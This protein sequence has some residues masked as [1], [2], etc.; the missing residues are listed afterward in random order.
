M[1]TWPSTLPAPLL[2]NYGLQ[3]TDP[4]ARTQMEQGSPRTRQRARL[5][6]TSVVVQWMLTTQQLATLEAWHREI[7]HNGADWFSI[8]LAN[9]LG[10]NTISARF[11]GMWKAS[12]KERGF[13]QIDATLEIADRPML[14]ATQLTPYL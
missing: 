7:I 6:P 14:T 8:S 2:A 10:K 1:A 9:G 3:P 13:W 4:V 12:L 11:L 5:A